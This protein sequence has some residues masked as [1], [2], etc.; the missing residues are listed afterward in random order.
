MLPEKALEVRLMSSSSCLR[1]ATAGESSPA[2]RLMDTSSDVTRTAARFSARG[3]ARARLHS[4]AAL[5]LRCSACR[6]LPR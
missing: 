5:A 3:R 2:R 6:H 4:A 1:L